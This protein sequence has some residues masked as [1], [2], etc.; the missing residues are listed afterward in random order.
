M[1]AVGISD[2]VGAGTVEYGAAA[3][4]VRSIDQI[5]SGREPISGLGRNDSGHLPVSDQLI[6]NSRGVA[7]KALILAKRQV[8][9]VTEHEAMTNVEIG[10]AI[11]QS[12]VGLQPEV[13][14]ILRAQ[15]GV[16][17]VVQ[18][19]TVGIGRFKL[20]AIGESLDRKSVV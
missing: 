8:I 6:Q 20:E 19:M 7:A 5:V 10:I 11:L 15:I 16:G 18:R 1:R 12:R 4:G 3:I 9:D 17:S 2:D 14:L 13:T